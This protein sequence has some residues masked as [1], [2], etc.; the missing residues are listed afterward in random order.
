MMP[1]IAIVA[2][3]EREVEG[4]VKDWASITRVYYARD[5]KILSD[6][7]IAV[8]CGG[9]GAVPAR[10][11]AEAIASVHQPQV[12]ISAGFAGAT[13]SGFEIGAPLTPAAVVDAASGK[14]YPTLFGSGAIVTVHTVVGPKEKANIFAKF[15]ADA[16]D[17]EAAGV[18]EVAQQRGLTF[19]CA[20][21]ISDLPDFDLPPIQRFVGPDGE[22]ETGRLVAFAA[23]RP[24]MWRQLRDLAAHSARAAATLTHVLGSILKDPRLTKVPNS[25]AVPEEAHK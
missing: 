5:Y 17:M 7:D 16:V 19:L 12:L 6:G 23:F 22:L 18:A 21:A 24:V 3:M 9:I 11:A 2:A 10:R 25:A 13:R 8:I 4:L 14:R 1:R 20:K 15:S